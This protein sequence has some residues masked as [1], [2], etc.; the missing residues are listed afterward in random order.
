MKYDYRNK[1]EWDEWLRAQTV[2]AI[3]QAVAVAIG[4][5]LC[6]IIAALT[7]CRS[8]KSIVTEQTATVTT[9]AS[10]RT[11]TTTA[12]RDSTHTTQTWHSVQRDTTTTQ[13]WHTIEFAPTGGTLTIDSIGT[14]HATNVTAYLAHTTATHSASTAT[15]K[16]ADS[17]AVSAHSTDIHTSRDTAYTEANTTTT[18]TPTA[19][20][21]ALT[22][23]QRTLMRIGQL[24]LAALLITAAYIWL[25]R[26]K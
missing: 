24:A 16:A 18:T 15:S 21:T 6:A 20:T 4:I 22:W 14:L 1:Q 26:R 19:S 11:D 3:G 25:K 10:L 8:H 23:W 9:T 5:L 17:T 7:G 12:E 2:K 13:T